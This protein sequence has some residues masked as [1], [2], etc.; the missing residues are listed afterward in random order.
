MRGALAIVLA[1]V[2]CGGGAAESLPHDAGQAPLDASGAAEA[3]E[4]ASPDEVGA[5]SGGNCSGSGI[6]KTWASMDHAPLTATSAANLDLAENGGI[7]LA[8]AESVLCDGTELPALRDGDH[9]EA[10]GASNEV[11]LVFDATTG[12]G[13]TLS[14]FPGY[15]GAFAFKSDPSEG[16]QHSYS[17]GLGPVMKDG[18]PLSMVWTS[19]PFTAGNEVFNALMYTYG[20]A[21]GVYDGPIPSCT[22]VSVCP[23]NTSSGVAV[24]NIVPL[25]ITFTFEGLSGEPAA[26]TVKEID[27]SV[28]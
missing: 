24:W 13:E 22:A 8:E 20:S 7:T 19:T 2:S 18:A 23:F 1:C 10:W 5:P 12:D 3:S 4:E 15:L 16:A 25:G 27:W 6:G 14:L 21:L 11:E 28:P 26:S 17:I 9:V